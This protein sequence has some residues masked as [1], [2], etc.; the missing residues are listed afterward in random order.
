L[1]EEEKVKHV[2]SMSSKLEALQQGTRREQPAAE[3][4]YA[5]FDQINLVAR[6]NQ[7]AALGHAY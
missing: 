1:K 6:I 7:F 3:N 4:F 5:S 2:I